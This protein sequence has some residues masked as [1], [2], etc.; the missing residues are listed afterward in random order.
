MSA[1]MLLVI[2]DDLKVLPDLLDR[3]REIGVSGTTILSSLGGYRASSWLERVGLGMLGQGFEADELN[4]RTLISIIE[5]D[6]LLERAIAE[7]EQIVGGFDRPDSGA[8][9]VLPVTRTLGLKKRHDPT[10]EELIATAPEM[11]EMS[12][13]DRMRCIPVSEVLAIHDFQPAIVEPD[14]SLAEVATKMLNHPS[15]HVACVINEEGRLCGIVRLEAI[16]NDLFMRL[17]PEEFLHELSEL[18]EALEFADHLK[19]RTAA[20]AMEEPVI[21]HPGDTI[22]SAFHRMHDL[23]LPGLPVVDDSHHV[24]GYVNLLEML[25]LAA[26]GHH[27]SCIG[28]IQ[29]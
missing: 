13:L 26:K 29:E 18:K 7:T 8:L 19:H 3:W 9:F 27:L 23:K 17:M 25:A 10:S 15:T 12:E 11:G 16:V 21:I 28:D 1:H 20:D 6:D 2:L 24:I 4:Q 22:R 5:D 14:D